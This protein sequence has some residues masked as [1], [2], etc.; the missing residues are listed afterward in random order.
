MTLKRIPGAVDLA[1]E[2]WTNKAVSKKRL[3]NLHADIKGNLDH[4]QQ[5]LAPIQTVAKGKLQVMAGILKQAETGAITAVQLQGMM[6]TLKQAKDDVKQCSED[7][8]QLNSDYFDA[9]ADWR[10]GAFTAIPK[11]YAELLGKIRTAQQNKVKEVAGKA[12]KVMEDYSVRAGALSKQLFAL[13]GQ[14]AS[15]LDVARK[16][17]SLVT[18]LDP[19]LRSGTTDASKSIN[20]LGRIERNVG[21]KDK[22]K[23]K[24]AVN[25][26]SD[27]LKG[28][29]KLKA[30]RKTIK[31]VHD[32]IVKMVAP[33]DFMLFR[34]SKQQMIHTAREALTT[35]T[36][37][38]DRVK[39][40]H[41][42]TDAA[43]KSAKATIPKWPPK[44]L[45]D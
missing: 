20:A 35:V 43:I 6:P 41:L 11:P 24:D 16:A 21:D 36:E 19:L 10:N 4:F 32:A 13:S 28:E 27:V 30:N 7:A 18:K 40:A 15:Y 45:L 12:A 22:A 37:Q 23:Q 29:I 2:D 8:K 5:A 33:F 31:E 14:A 25:S 38:C 9:H 34:N 42:R 26:V 1:R 3:D 17:Q 39:T 44:C